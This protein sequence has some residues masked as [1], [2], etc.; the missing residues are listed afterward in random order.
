MNATTHAPSSDFERLQQKLVP[1]W[2]QIGTGPGGPVQDENT[3]VVVPSLSFDVDVP[4][5]TLMAYEQ[6]FLFLLFLLRQPNLRLIY[7]TSQPVQPAIIDYYLGLLPGVVYSHA[8][9]RLDLVCVEDGS[10]TPLSRKLLDRPHV[11]ARIRNLIPNPDL[12]HLIP[13]NTTDLE[14]ELA[15]A[16]GIPM[17]AADPD[18]YAFGT[19]SGGR[20]IFAEEGVPHPLGHEDLGSE[21]EV[22]DA[23]CAM[24]A[25]RPA[26]QK[27]I[28]KLNEGVSGMGNAL[29]DLSQLPDPGDGSESDAVTEALRSM[30]F[31]LPGVQYE[32]YMETLCDGG[33]IVEEVITGRELVS[34]SAQLR[35]TPLGEVEMLSTHDQILGGPS[36]QTYLGARFPA[37][38]AY[39]WT[40]MEQAE[41]VAQRLAREG[42]I[43]RFAVDF[44]VVQDDADQWQPYAIEI[45]LR[46]GG[47]TAPHL[48][49]EYLTD[50]RY[51]AQAGIFRTVRG[52]EKCYVASDHV[53][54][55]AYRVFTPDSLMD[56]VSRHRL[57]FDHARQTGVVMHMLCN[58]GG[59]GRLGAT[60]IADS[61]EEADALYDRFV[62]VLDM[63]AAQCQ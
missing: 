43:G 57:H 14:R 16:L 20:R 33:G 36:G 49:L 30:L 7:V 39:A 29:V 9:K 59:S 61:H 22:V 13:F 37:N 47:T 5:S 40:I 62:D 10:A 8:H 12:A 48:T 35:I 32:T 51:D 6:R 53:E 44:V 60:V 38:E 1:L 45:N 58:V 17:Y 31:E 15:M 21:A 3:A 28:A 56:I 55:E 42:V 23:I 4:A 34:P 46:K 2:M 24:R 52:D 18:F 25:Q 63:E 11:L 41:K 27:V 54:S 19:K 26:M 50:G